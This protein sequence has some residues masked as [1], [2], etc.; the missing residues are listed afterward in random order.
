MQVPKWKARSNFQSQIR[1]KQGT[2]VELKTE[3][4]VSRRSRVRVTEALPSARASDVKT[5]SAFDAESSASNSASNLKLALKRRTADFQGHS[6]QRGNGGLNAEQGEDDNK[7]E[8]RRMCRLRVFLCMSGPSLASEK[9][10]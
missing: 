6:D 8:M 9:L 10:G 4:E 7:E 3:T 5:A 2:L 1:L